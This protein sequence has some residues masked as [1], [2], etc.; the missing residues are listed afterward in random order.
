MNKYEDKHSS[1]TKYVHGNV[2][3]SA[4]ITFAGAGFFLSFLFDVT[5]IKFNIMFTFHILRYCLYTSVNKCMREWCVLC[6]TTNYCSTYDLC[7]DM[8]MET[9]NR[10][11][12]FSYSKLIM[13]SIYKKIQLN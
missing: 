7:R 2:C 8:W 1:T 9:V 12:K 5:C 3:T 10:N 11:G 13:V 6:T 4:S